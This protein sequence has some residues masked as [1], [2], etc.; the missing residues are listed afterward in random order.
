VRLL[1]SPPRALLCEVADAGWDAPAQVLY[2]GALL[3][4]L[5]AGSF[6][7]VRQ[8]LLRR[9]LEAA[10]KEL[11]ERVRSGNATHEELY[12]YGVV[13]LRKKVFS[14]ATKSLE[15]ALAA[16][17]AIADTAPAGEGIAAVHNAL[18]Y[19]LIGQDRAAE[20]LAQF[21]AAVTL[22]PGY[23]TAWNN[24]GDALEKQKLFADA[25]EAYTQALTYEPGNAVAQERAGFLR[26]RRVM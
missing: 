21:R 25:L 19:A 13:L 23:V 4:F 15:A 24:L 17:P 12:E 3:S 8:V 6:L 16:W 14:S 11:G 7:V 10:A 18:G 2:L 1:T 5:G 20:A 22:Q 26:A 9:E